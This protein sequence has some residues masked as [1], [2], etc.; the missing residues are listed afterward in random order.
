MEH[1]PM[2]SASLES[3]LPSNKLPQLPKNGN[4][5]E[6]SD[7]GFPEAIGLPKL[8][9]II[10]SVKNT[11]EYLSQNAVLECPFQTPGVPNSS[12][13]VARHSLAE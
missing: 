3:L 1:S 2:L 13:S 12:Q 10:I 4:Y 6:S 9:A 7:L 11:S 8:C 5:G